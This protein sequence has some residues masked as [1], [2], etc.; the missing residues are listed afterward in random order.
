MIKIER[1]WV[2][3][4]EP[5]NLPKTLKT[6]SLQNNKIKLLECMFGGPLHEEATQNSL[7]LHLKS[8]DLSRN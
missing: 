3:Y 6:L 1:C 4:F 7:C 8:V 2:T 5:A